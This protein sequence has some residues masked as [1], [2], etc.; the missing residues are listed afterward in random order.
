MLASLVKKRLG[1]YISDKLT[2][3]HLTRLYHRYVFFTL[4]TTIPNPE[5]VDLQIWRVQ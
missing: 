2:F 3:R 4:D 5:P 1:D